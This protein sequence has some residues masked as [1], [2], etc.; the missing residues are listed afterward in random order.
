MEEENFL[1]SSRNS[2]GLFSSTKYLFGIS[3]GLAVLWIEYTVL[4][5]NQTIENLE[6]V[7]ITLG[8]LG[9]FYFMYT[10]YDLHKFLNSISKVDYPITPKQAAFKH[11]IPFYNFYWVVKW[12]NTINMHF[13]EVDKKKRINKYGL[14]LLATYFIERFDGGISILIRHF[15]LWRLGKRLIHGYESGKIIHSIENE[16]DKEFI[17]KLLG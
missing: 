11:L 17:D 13:Y 10:V 5:Q 3:F 6:V 9:Y 16:G 14:I 12:T 8:I 15:V 2:I 4:I 1:D 7:L